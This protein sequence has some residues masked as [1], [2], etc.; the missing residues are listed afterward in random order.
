MEYL[1]EL[2]DLLLRAALLQEEA[3]R[4]GALE[5]APRL[6]QLAHAVLDEARVGRGALA[7][8]RRTKDEG[9]P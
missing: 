1:H 7:W 8:R 9:G 5:H 3:V 4:V 2:K 6:Q